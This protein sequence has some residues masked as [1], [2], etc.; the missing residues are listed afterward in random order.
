MAASSPSPCAQYP[1]SAPSSCLRRPRIGP[2]EDP[3]VVGRVLGVGDG[4]RLLHIGWQPHQRGRHL[5][6]HVHRSACDQPR[7]VRIRNVR[8][9]VHVG[10]VIVGIAR[11]LLFRSAQALSAPAGPGPPAPCRPMSCCWSPELSPD[12][13]VQRGPVG[14][15]SR[16]RLPDELPPFDL[17]SAPGACDAAR[18]YRR[19]SSR[20]PRRSW[21]ASRRGLGLGSAFQSPNPTH[22]PSSWPAFLMSKAQWSCRPSSAGTPPADRAPAAAGA[23]CRRRHPAAGS[24]S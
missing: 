5:R 20:L 23:P 12:G 2:T 19:R 9:R 4:H 24:P 14:V 15:R 18:A 8:Q 3:G 22:D 16:S 6:A 17:P 11:L 10:H 21:L 1:P 7:P 13:P